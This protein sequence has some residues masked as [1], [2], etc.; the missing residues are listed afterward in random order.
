MCAGDRVTGPAVLVA[1]RAGEVESVVEQLRGAEPGPLGLDVG[2]VARG[3]A[4]VSAS[5][6][7]E[8]HAAAL[9]AGLRA[10]GRRATL[11]PPGAGRLAAW[12]H[13]TQPVVVGSRLWVGFPWSQFEREGWPDAAAVVEI[14]PGAAFGAGAHP[15]TRLL[16]AELAA[17]LTGGESV[18]D[19]GC[20]SGVLAVSAARLG[21]SS[22][23]AIDVE[24]AAVTA[25]EA[26]AAWN[27]VNGLIDASI[28]PL[29]QIK[30]RYGV[31]LANIGAAALIAMAPAL[32]ACL[33]PG[34]WLG[35]SGL[36]PAQLSVVAAAF[37]AASILATPCLDEWAALTL[38]G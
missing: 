28:T 37:P 36:S 7:A 34:G 18:L 22:V 32:W 8:S 3:R 27:D 1:V 5:F 31:V 6:A 4:L 21:A 29:D 23:R 17:R 10:G 13:A 20:G 35:L 15:S 11:R 30:G 33:E 38:T 26:N 19:V 2:P 14:D 12:D 24:P 16:L 25:T 9:V